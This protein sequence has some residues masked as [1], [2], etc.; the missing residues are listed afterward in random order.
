MPSRPTLR[1]VLL[2]LA[3]MA[4][5]LLAAGPA[6]ADPSGPVVIDTHTSVHPP[7]AYTLTSSASGTL[8]GS[9]RKGGSRIYFRA[10][11]LASGTL[12]VDLGPDV[13]RFGTESIV[14]DKIAIPVVSATGDR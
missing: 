14:G 3:L 4:P 1:S 11:P 2:T 12:D 10:A 8:Y 9:D 7:E 13:S 5:G 6:A